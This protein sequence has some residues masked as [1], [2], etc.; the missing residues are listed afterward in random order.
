MDLQAVLKTR[1]FFPDKCVRARYGVRAVSRQLPTH[2]FCNSLI[3]NDIYFS[4][5][6]GQKNA[7]SLGGFMIPA[8]SFFTQA[9]PG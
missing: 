2:A 5:D 8:R 9:Q 6:R 4:P 7:T 1:G 3:L